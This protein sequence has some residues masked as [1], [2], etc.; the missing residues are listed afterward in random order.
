M[1]SCVGSGGCQGVAA[2]GVPLRALQVCIALGFMAV[3]A[4]LRY[5][6]DQLSHGLCISVHFTYATQSSRQKVRICIDE[7]A[8]PIP[9]F[10]R[11]AIRSALNCIEAQIEQH[12]VV[13]R[14]HRYSNGVT[15]I[16]FWLAPL[17]PALS[18]AGPDG[19]RCPDDRRGQQSQFDD[20]SENEFDN[21]NGVDSGLQ[22]QFGSGYQQPMD[23]QQMELTKQAILADMER[24]LAGLSNYEKASSEDTV[25]ERTTAGEVQSSRVNERPH[26][27]RLECQL[28]GHRG[29]VGHRDS[30]LGNDYKLDSDFQVDYAQLEAVGFQGLDGH[31]GPLNE[32]F[33]NDPKHGI[34]YELGHD[35]ELSLQEQSGFDHQNSMDA[36]QMELTKQA[37]LADMD[38]KLAGLPNYVKASS[39]QFDNVQAR[40]TAGEAQSSSVNE[41]PHT[42]Q[43]RQESEDEAA[44]WCI[45]HMTQIKMK[46]YTFR[47]RAA[48]TA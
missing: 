27:A 9:A 6:H 47:R 22:E 16:C 41:W 46:A 33:G 21:E 30:V 32:Q 7:R 18:E 12:A 31:R 43:A 11:P 40:A 39:E 29:L 24:K 1:F 34:Y 48:Q 20:G 5:I 28:A 3:A 17:P 23:A 19:H 37:I 14:G 44:E 10:G 38:R 2:F 13:D 8:P 36:Q 42:A 26:T 4:R 25:Q 15:E 35:Y 45:D